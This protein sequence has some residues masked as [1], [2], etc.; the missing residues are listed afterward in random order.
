MTYNIAVMGPPRKMDSYSMRSRMGRLFI[1]IVNRLKLQSHNPT[2]RNAL[3]MLPTELLQQISCELPLVDLVAF[4]LTHKTILYVVGHEPWRLLARDADEKR[5]FLALLERDLPDTWLCHCQVILRRKAGIQ[6]NN[7]RDPRCQC[8][9]DHIRYILQ[10]YLTWPMINLVMKHHL[11]GEDHGLPVSTLSY[12]ENHHASKRYRSCPSYQ[13]TM[14]A[15]IVAGEVLVRTTYQLA[16]P[17]RDAVHM[18]S[19]CAHLNFYTDCFRSSSRLDK[20]MLSTFPACGFHMKTWGSPCSPSYIGLRRCQ[21]CA[22]E[23]D[24]SDDP[25]EGRASIRIQVWQNLG[26]GHSPAEP[27]WACATQSSWKLH[28]KEPLKL[29]LGSIRTAYETDCQQ[30]EPP[31]M[32]HTGPGVWER[33]S[34]RAALGLIKEY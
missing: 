31:R 16:L 1:G 11:L 34:I 14:Q 19:P 18:F 3:L 26:S 28:N 17:S 2:Q 27:K 12:A 9:D 33:S 29:G 13:F 23:Y 21:Y 10:V 22:T 8:E 4:T 15:K 30:P 32:R 5:S 25:V 20:G 6:V 7:F 24:I